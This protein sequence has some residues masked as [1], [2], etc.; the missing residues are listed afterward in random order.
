[1][2]KGSDV[3][4]FLRF[5]ASNILFE[6]EFET[7]ILLAKILLEVPERQFASYAKEK[8]A[9][10]IGSIHNG[11]ERQILSEIEIDSK[12]KVAYNEKNSAIVLAFSCNECE[13][14]LLRKIYIEISSHLSAH[15]LS[16]G[17]ILVK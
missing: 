9:L 13:K 7:E 2:F 5:K 12:H 3:K 4:E 16:S 11:Q 8:T 1:L 15:I 6:L 10:K 14:L 17:A